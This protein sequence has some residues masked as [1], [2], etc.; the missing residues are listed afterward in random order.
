MSAKNKKISKYTPIRKE[1][2]KE[3]G[4]PI[5]YKPSDSIKALRR[6]FRKHLRRKDVSF[7]TIS[8]LAGID[9]SALHRFKND[10][11]INLKSFLRLY[12]Y[13]KQFGKIE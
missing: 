5:T 13:L 6:A 7:R 12:A 3:L 10:K 8:Y 11:D 4:T 9:H 1:I 2:S